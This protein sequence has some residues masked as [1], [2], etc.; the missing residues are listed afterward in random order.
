MHDRPTSTHS[1]KDG[2]MNSY[3]RL[4][5]FLSVVAAGSVQ[6]QPKRI[7]DFG[8]KEFSSAD[9]V[10]ALGEVRGVTLN[11]DDSTTR[12][13]T[14]NKEHGKEADAGEKSPRRLSVR[15]Q[16]ALNSAEL[17]APAKRRLDAIGQAL[18]DAELATANLLVSGHTD[19]TGRYDSNLRLSKRRADAVK[20]YLVS[21]H[22]VAPGRLKAVGRGP[23]E[24]IEEGNPASPIN[25]RVQFAVIE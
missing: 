5:L 22:D 14:L 1:S 24:P 15:L 17:T 16:F 21:A 25:R 6:A 7:V 18:G 20:L 12:G 8:D 10:R 2:I 13:L 19:S 4:A 3:L 23:D 11:K 9:V